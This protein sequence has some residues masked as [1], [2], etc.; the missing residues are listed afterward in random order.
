MIMC[1]AILTIA[2]Y[3]SA[4]SAFPMITE[5]I[6][7]FYC[8]SVREQKSRAMVVPGFAFI[9]KLGAEPVISDC[10]SRSGLLGLSGL[11]QFFPNA[12]FFSDLAAFGAV[13]L[14]D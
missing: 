12:C 13:G 2:Y 1:S 11:P 6:G 4:P 3:R 7:K 14:G 10:P 8:H 5:G 9:D